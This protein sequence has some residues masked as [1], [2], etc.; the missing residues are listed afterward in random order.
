MN[1]VEIPDGTIRKNTEYG[2]LTGSLLNKEYEISSLF[3]LIFKCTYHILAL[4][5]EMLIAIL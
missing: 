2:Y 4:M 3:S 1:R 5:T